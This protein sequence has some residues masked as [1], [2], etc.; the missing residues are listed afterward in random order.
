MISR[1]VRV[2]RF[3]VGSS[4]RNTSGSLTRERAMATPV[5]ASVVAPRQLTL[6]ARWSF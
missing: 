4:T 3:P 5:P 2:S 6:G 1:L